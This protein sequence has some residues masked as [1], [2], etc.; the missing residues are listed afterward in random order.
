VTHDPANTLP[1]VADSPSD[2]GGQASEREL[3]TGYLDWYRS[4]VEGKVADLSLQDGSRI[5]TP[6]GLSPLGIVKHLGDVEQSWF[7]QRFAGEEVELPGDDDFHAAFRIET[8]ET[9]ASV[10]A[11]YHESAEHSRRIVN[12]SPL[13]A[14][15][16]GDEHP[17]FG[18]VSLRW[19]MVH[20]LEET[21]RHAGHL[22]L[23]REEIDGKTGD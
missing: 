17:V 2:L 6:T 7:R 20:M 4:I 8:G 22:D 9:C 5:M 14:L 1:P 19:I 10:L 13:D 11:F 23:M 15:S 21:A 12:A 16:A 3:L 18:R